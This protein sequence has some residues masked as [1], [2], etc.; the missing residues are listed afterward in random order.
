MH[1]CERG[2]EQRLEIWAAI[3][4][5]FRG[6]SDRENYAALNAEN[7]AATFHPVGSWI[8]NQLPR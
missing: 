2:E 3:D 4:K 1:F 7:N 6:V 8:P 5:H